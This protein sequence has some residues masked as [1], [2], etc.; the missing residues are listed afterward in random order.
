MGRLPEGGTAVRKGDGDAHCGS[1]VVVL[2]F[3]HLCLGA[4]V[5]HQAVVVAVHLN[6]HRLRPVRRVDLRSSNLRD[7]RHSDGVA[8]LPQTLGLRVGSTP[9]S[10]RQDAR[11]EQRSVEGHGVGGAEVK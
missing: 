5:V 6:L 11:E 1:G 2:G 7:L 10:G 3:G 9:E 8:A 4:E